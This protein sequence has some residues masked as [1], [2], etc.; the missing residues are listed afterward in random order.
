MALGKVQEDMKKYADRHRGKAEEY[1]VGDLVL[2]STKD[3]KYQMVGRRMEKLMERF[4]GPYR[5]KSIVSTN[6]L[7]L[8]LPSTVKIHLVVNVSRVQRY[9]GQVEGQRK[10]MPQ[11]VVIEVS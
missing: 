11:L 1:R 9:T 4:V 7:E 3:L 8:E 2:L 10:E 6:T 5:V